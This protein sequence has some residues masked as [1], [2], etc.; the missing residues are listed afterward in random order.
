MLKT[1]SFRIYP[2][3]IISYILRYSVCFVIFE[4]FLCLRISYFFIMI[5]N[6]QKLNRILWCTFVQSLFAIAPGYLQPIISY[7]RNNCCWECEKD[8]IFSWLL[9]QVQLVQNHAQDTPNSIC[10]RGISWVCWLFYV[11]DCHY[12]TVFENNWTKETGE[13]EFFCFIFEDYS[14]FF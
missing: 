2:L 14:L 12:F 7:F 13:T 10:Y 3:S 1:C 5:A 4:F 8:C 11:P 9:N 6:L